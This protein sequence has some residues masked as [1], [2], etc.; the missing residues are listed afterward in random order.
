MI[1]DK[2]LGKKKHKSQAEIV[3][4]TIVMVLIML[5]IVFVI[6]FVIIPQDENLKKIYD[7]TQI[8]ANFYDAM[9]LTDT[10]CNGQS[11]RDLI[12]NCF[13]SFGASG[14]P[15]P[16]SQYLCNPDLTLGLDCSNSD[17]C[18]SC[19][20]VNRTIEYLLDQSLIAIN[21]PFD[22][23]ICSWDTIKKECEPTSIISNFS[24]KSCLNANKGH[25]SKQTIIPTQVGSRV[26][27]IYIC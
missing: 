5:G 11:M 14:R 18:K 7:K 22:L 13:E 16:L 8:G 26:I 10:N 4:I 15:D 9:L 23:Q 21:Q 12:A 20:Y 19:N 24:Y 25:D 27:Q 17:D 1:Q 3:G 6:K 2:L